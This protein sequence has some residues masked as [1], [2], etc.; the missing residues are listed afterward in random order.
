MI[1]SNS[2]STPYGSWLFRAEAAPA[3]RPVR[4]FLWAM[5]EAHP[6]MGS[7]AVTSLHILGEGRG[8]NGD[9]ARVGRDGPPPDRDLVLP[10][11]LNA[12]R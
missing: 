8:P 7:Y 1:M 12:P 3:S 10:C 11:L 5:P 4:M 6:R 2:A 9:A